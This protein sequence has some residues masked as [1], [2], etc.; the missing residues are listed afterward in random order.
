MKEKLSKMLKSVD[1]LKNETMRLGTDAGKTM[2]Q[3]KKV[4]QVG[5]ETSK[6][7]LN[8]AKGF[9]ENDRIHQGMEL[10]SKG[11]DMMAKGARIASK[12]ANTLASTMEKASESVKRI[13]KKRK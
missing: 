6:S 7:A 10:T 9:T 13:G 12:G 8:K 3:V 11:I 2:S 5:V 4:I 1:D